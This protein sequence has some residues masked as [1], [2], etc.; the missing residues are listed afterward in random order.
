V[1]KAT[2][3]KESAPAP[4]PLPESSTSDHVFLY[5]DK[6]HIQVRLDEILYVEAAGNYS[7]VVLKD[8]YVLVREKISELIQKFSSEHFMQVHK[9]FIVAKAHI[10]SVEGNRIMISDAIIPIGS[11]YKSNVVNLLKG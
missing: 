9:S 2:V 6:K 5:S 4:T 10:N 1:N 11:F 7:K 8:N 3:V